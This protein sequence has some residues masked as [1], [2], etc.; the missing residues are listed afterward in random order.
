[1]PV[2]IIPARGGSKRI[3]RKNIK[4]FQ[5]KPLLGHVIEKITGAACFDHIIVSTD[6]SE[7]ADVASQFGAKTPFTRP[8]ELA[9]DFSTT[10]Q[11]MAHAFDQLNALGLSSHEV[12]CVYPTAIFLRADDLLE[13]LRQF[14][15]NE[16]QCVM[17]AATFLAPVQRSFTRDVDGGMAMLFEDEFTSRSQDL[18]PHYYDAGQFYWA[19]E[20]LWRSKLPLFDAKS[21]FV[22]IPEWAS[23][24]LDNEA[25]WLE[26]EIKARVLMEKGMF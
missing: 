1:M 12:C 15:T 4:L 5:G 7:I 26:M 19:T 17:A 22:T 10:K 11:V 2:C 8:A 3:P 20:A 14:R 6:D 25:D 9:D 13:G 21:T 24:D 16:W 23:C 18:D